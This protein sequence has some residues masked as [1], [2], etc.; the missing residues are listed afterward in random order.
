MIIIG[1]NIG[2]IIAGIMA[3]VRGKFVLTKN[4]VVEG[5]PAR[6][7]GAACFIPLPVVLCGSVTFLLVRSGGAVREPTT[8]DQLLSAAIE[9]GIMIV[10]LLILFG[11][12]FALSGPPSEDRPP[13]RRWDDDDEEDDF[14]EDDDAPRRRR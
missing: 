8:E 6:L 11:T 1:M 5:V 2:L 10:S 3:L 12:A 7:L 9:W 14:E 4:R 13:P